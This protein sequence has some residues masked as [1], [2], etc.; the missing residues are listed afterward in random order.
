VSRLSRQCGILNI[1]QPYRPPWPGTGIALLLLYL[2]I[3]SIESSYFI[4]IIHIVLAH[5]RVMS[6]VAT[7]CFVPTCILFISALPFVYICN[8]AEIT[9]FPFF[10]QESF[11]VLRNRSDRSN[12][13]RRTNLKQVREPNGFRR[14]VKRNRGLKK[15]TIWLP[16]V[17][18]RCVTSAILR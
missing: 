17:T 10:C 16:E 7:S 12:T 2:S 9:L 8:I 6:C 15:T 14:K 11:A 18:S 1:S 13:K 4:F 5:G 3:H